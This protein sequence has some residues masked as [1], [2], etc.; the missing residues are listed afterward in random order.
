LYTKD[1]KPDV[2]LS[3]FLL[4]LDIIRV[5]TFFRGGI[6]DLII[7]TGGAGF[8]GSAV[9]WGLNKRGIDNILIV[10][11][12]GDDD[13]WKN[14]RG[15][16]FSDYIE[17]DAFIEKI[18]EGKL[19][20]AIE[21]IFHLGA[22]SDTLCRDARFFIFNNYEYSKELAMFCIK[23]NI[24]FIYAS[25]AAT[26]G[27]GGAGYEDDEDRLETLRP[28][29]M[30][31]Y[32]KQLFDLW[33]KKQG[34]LKNI[35]G[36]KYF[37]VFGPNEYHKAEMRSKILK[38]F[39]EIKETGKIKLFKSYRKEYRDGY[40]K[41]DFLYIK[42]AVDMT[43]F[44]MD[45]ID[46]NGIYNIGEGKA[47]AWIDL[48]N[49]VF[50]ALGKK[51]EIEFIDMPEDLK[52]RYQYFTEADISKIRRAGYKENIMSFEDA[53]KDYVCNYLIHHKHLDFAD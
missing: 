46:K 33:A 27:D 37:N 34:I 50:G 32:S 48:A 41:R 19:D 40:Q 36:L 5:T 21:I 13:K 38:A 12:L 39:Y 30:Y 8:I 1:E 16:K 26:Y 17:K 18:I 20:F 3:C 4:L 45:K 6:K 28:L 25:S 31:G 29:N 11:S 9:C 22:C 2:C 23:K 7:V 35:V 51:T 49:A 15:L 24:R 52:D 10:D 47:R 53:V 14:I 44:F 42:D 43:L